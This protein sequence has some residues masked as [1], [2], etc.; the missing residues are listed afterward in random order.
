MTRRLNISSGTAWESAV[1]Y[2]RAVRAGNV[3]VVAGTT[4]VDE[5]GKVVGAGDLHAQTRFVL[6]KIGRALREAG[7]SFSDVVSTRSFVTDISRWEE[8]GRAHAEIFRE[9]RPTCTL[10]EVK[11]LVRPDM[12][13]E[14]EVMAVVEGCEGSAA[15]RTQERNGWSSEV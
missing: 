8:F 15:G 10:V 9:I 3:V 13:V 12:L 7:A 2:S 11:G 4:A 6:Q 5:T 1:G 14:I